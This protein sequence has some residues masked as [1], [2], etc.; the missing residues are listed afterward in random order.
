MDMDRDMGSDCGF[1]YGYTTLNFCL[2]SLVMA[3]GLACSVRVFI[4]SRTTGNTGLK[5][6]EEEWKDLGSWV[7]I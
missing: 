6:E 4:V 7:E 2:G 1:G 5:K 3:V